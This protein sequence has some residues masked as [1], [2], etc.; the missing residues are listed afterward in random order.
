MERFENTWQNRKNFKQEI[1]S[2]ILSRFII[3]YE[4]Q[5]NVAYDAFIE[6]KMEFT[7]KSVT[8]QEN[9]FYP[10]YFFSPFCII[11][12]V[13]ARKMKNQEGETIKISQKWCT[14]ITLVSI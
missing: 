12:F 7:F 5:N 8:S 4:H 10:A 3:K 1:Q 9:K 13:A 14:R 6:I 2:V 11:L